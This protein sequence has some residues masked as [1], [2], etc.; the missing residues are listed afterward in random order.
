LAGA[1]IAATERLW[2]GPNVPNGGRSTAHAEQIGAT[3]YHNGKKV[4]CGL[5]SQTAMW[6][7]PTVCM[8]K[9]SGSKVERTDGRK[10]NDRLDYQTEQFFG[11]PS[12]PDP[13]IMQDGAACSTIGHNSNQQPTKRKLNPFFV[14]A[15]MRWPIGLSGFE[16]RATEWTQW[17]QLMLSYLSMLCSRPEPAQAELF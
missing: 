13:T 4:Q 14:E 6:A 5:E 15:L 16:R 17:Q 3:M 2:M 8:T 7:G 9:G 10:R 1:A 12:S 11:L